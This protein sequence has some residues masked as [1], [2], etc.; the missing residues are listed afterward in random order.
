MEGVLGKIPTEEDI[1]KYDEGKINIG[2]TIQSFVDHKGFELL[3]AIF[4]TEV[5]EIKNKDD[6]KTIED[7]KAD[8]KA[9]KIVRTMLDELQSYIDN[10]E[11]AIIRLNKLKEAESQ[12]PS[13]LSVD[14]EGT[15]EE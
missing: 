13:L 8:R 14:G 9:I 15:D 1:R 5:A 3:M 12:T 10:S 7:F 2:R 4:A 11:H 6:Y